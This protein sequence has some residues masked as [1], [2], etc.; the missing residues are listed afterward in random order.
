[1]EKKRTKDGSTKKRR[2]PANPEEEWFA[3]KKAVD[4]EEISYQPTVVEPQGLRESM[5]KR[6]VR[7]M[8]SKKLALITL[9]LIFLEVSP[10]IPSIK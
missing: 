8:F 4:H 1:L 6:R 2:T 7:M 5:N 3:E 10:K 9:L